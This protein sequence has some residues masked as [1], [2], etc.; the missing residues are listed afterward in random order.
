M[1]GLAR[2]LPGRAVIVPVI[3][4]TG[5]TFPRARCCSIRLQ[6]GESTVQLNVDVTS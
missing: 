1:I 2:R 5:R 3:W 6:R 4:S